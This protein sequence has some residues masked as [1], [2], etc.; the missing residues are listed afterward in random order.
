M[1]APTT[2]TGD[3]CPG[4]LRLHHAADGDLAR[5]RIPGG[6]LTPHAT[7]TLAHLATT[8]GDGHIRLT[9][10]GN[11]E[12]RGIPTGSETDLGTCLT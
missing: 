2:P 1:T 3:R 11:A 10:R 4:A 8:L 5:I 7:R 6:L 12:I 9:A